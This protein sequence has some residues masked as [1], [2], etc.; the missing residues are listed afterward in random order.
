MITSLLIQRQSG[1]ATM[2]NE[3][4]IDISAYWDGTELD[5][6][7][8]LDGLRKLISILRRNEMDAYILKAEVT[9]SESANISTLK[10]EPRS[11]KLTLAIIN[12][13]ALFSGNLASFRLLA[14]NLEFLCEQWSNKNDQHLHFEPVSNRF[15][16]SPDSEA[17]IVSQRSSSVN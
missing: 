7:C 8:S 5:L 4:R 11:S 1:P 13:T 3:S 14:D 12:Q 6:M 16:F 9:G 17:F 10:I 15:L 2:A